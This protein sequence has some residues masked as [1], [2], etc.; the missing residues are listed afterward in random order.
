MRISWFVIGLLGCAHCGVLAALLVAGSS[1]VAEKL[2][3]DL[4]GRIK[5]EDAGFDWKVRD[6]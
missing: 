4:R 2:A 1:R 3:R 6:A 5:I